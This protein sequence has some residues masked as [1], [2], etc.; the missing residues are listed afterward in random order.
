[1]SA[2]SIHYPGDPATDSRSLDSLIRDYRNHREEII[3]KFPHS[4]NTL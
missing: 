1:M 3:K 4:E 2:Q